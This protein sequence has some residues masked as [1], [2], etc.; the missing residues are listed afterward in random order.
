MYLDLDEKKKHLFSL[1]REQLLDPARLSSGTSLSFY[2]W[3]NGD[4][5]M[6]NSFLNHTFILCVTIVSRNSVM[7]MF[8]SFP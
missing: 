6:Q 4:L 1:L 3:Y 5:Q 2:R 8:C 7:Q